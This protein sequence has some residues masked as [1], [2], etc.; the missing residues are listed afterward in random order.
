MDGTIALN[1]TA[2]QGMVKTKSTKKEVLKRIKEKLENAKL[3]LI[4]TELEEEGIPFERK[5]N[6][7]KELT[8]DLK[9][10]LSVLDYNKI[11][12]RKSRI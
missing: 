4:Y 9:L 8:A 7:V 5:Y 11:S 6:T 12:K 10:Q 3:Q 2:F 1:N